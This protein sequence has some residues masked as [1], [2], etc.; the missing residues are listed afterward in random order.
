MHCGGTDALIADVG[1]RFFGGADILINNA[2]TGS[3]K[4]VMEAPDEK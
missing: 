2:G 4:T 3:N 1:R